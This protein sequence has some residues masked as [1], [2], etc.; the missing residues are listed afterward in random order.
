MTNQNDLKRFKAMIG[1]FHSEVKSNSV[2]DLIVWLDCAME[3]EQQQRNE[4]KEAM[5]TPSSRRKD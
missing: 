4:H 3:L 1:M 2:T 5:G